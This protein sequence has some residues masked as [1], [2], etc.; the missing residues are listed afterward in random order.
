MEDASD[1]YCSG[2]INPE[3]PCMTLVT[4]Y[5]NKELQYQGKFIVDIIYKEILYNKKK[6]HSCLPIT[7]NDDILE[8]GGD[9]SPALLITQLWK[10][11]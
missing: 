8:Y 5:N 3:H 4:T 9:T 11:K 6:V 7:F 10:R 2:M 1:L